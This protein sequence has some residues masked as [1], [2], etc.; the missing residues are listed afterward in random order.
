MAIKNKEVLKDEVVEPIV[1]EVVVEETNV[2]EVIEEPVEETRNESVDNT[3]IRT[4][5]IA[6]VGNC[7]RLN[8]RAEAN[9][10]AEV[11]SILNVGS[12]VLINDEKSTDEFY[13]ISTSA[14]IE[15]FCMKGYIL[16]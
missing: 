3:F 14:G 10:N 7:D 2:E 15:G 16:K 5:K 9:I 12:E 1:E 13:N 4:D 8:V 11:I 6:I